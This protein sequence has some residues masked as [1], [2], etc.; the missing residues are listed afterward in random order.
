MWFKIYCA[1][2]FGGPTLLLIV[3][4]ITSYVEGDHI[5]PGFGQNNC[6]FAGNL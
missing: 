4:I 5:K 3:S 2:G 1:Y 6:W